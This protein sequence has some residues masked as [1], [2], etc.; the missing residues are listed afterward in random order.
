MPSSAT[1]K[2]SFVIKASGS[3]HPAPQVPKVAPKPAAGLGHPEAKWTWNSVDEPERT[4][5]IDG[6]PSKPQPLL[7]PH[8]AQP[9]VGNRLC[10]TPPPQP[11]V[12][13]QTAVG[14]QPVRGKPKSAAPR[15]PL[16]YLPPMPDQKPPP[17]LPL[18]G[19]ADV[20]LAREPK[21]VKKPPPPLRSGAFASQGPSSAVT[22]QR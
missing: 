9:T 10:K 2:H 14:K 12:G 11:Q 16:D 1:G 8:F 3:L 4:P 13:K 22:I 15:L 19:M 18:D 6:R 7:P 21:A 5:E 17:P 20:L